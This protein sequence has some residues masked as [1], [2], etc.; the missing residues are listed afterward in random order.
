MNL[1][2]YQQRIEDTWISND[3]DLERILLGLCGEA[4]E[5]AEKHKKLYRGDYIGKKGI[6]REALKKEIGDVCYYL[7]KLANMWELD[8]EDILQE[9]I[10]KLAKRKEE[11]KIKGSGDTR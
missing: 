9:N 1:K 3:K 8:L 4:G 5:I 6:F 11:G 2:E 10:D 7:G